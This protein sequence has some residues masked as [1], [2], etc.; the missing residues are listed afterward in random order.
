MLLVTSPLTFVA[1]TGAP[2][3]G[4]ESVRVDSTNGK[5]EN[6]HCRFH[7]L[8]VH[9]RGHHSRE[10]FWEEGFLRRNVLDCIY[11][12]SAALLLRN[13]GISRF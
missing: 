6:L 4:I 2:P 3:E 10:L 5:R 1:F 9:N 8:P 12:T 7:S 11:S 13:L